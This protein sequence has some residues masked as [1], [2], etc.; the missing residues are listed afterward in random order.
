MAQSGEAKL[1]ITIPKE[2]HTIIKSEAVKRHITLRELITNEIL[3]KFKKE[4]CEFGY[5]HKLNAKTKAR[6][7]H[8]A[9][10]PE[11]MKTFKNTEDMMSYLTNLA[12]NE[13]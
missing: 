11:E 13:K 3:D 7:E 9:K 8:S 5:E 12:K 10:H 6:L 4:L 1:I 2:L